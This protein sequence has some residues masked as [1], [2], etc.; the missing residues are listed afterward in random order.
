MKLN[1]T[2]IVAFLAVS[3]QAATVEWGILTGPDWQYDSGERH[4]RGLVTA[5]ENCRMSTGDV[6]C[7]WLSLIGN[8]SADNARIVLSAEETSVLEYGD[9]WV[10]MNE[11]DLVDATIQDADTFFLHGIADPV[12][13][14][15]DVHSDYTIEGMFASSFQFYLGFATSVC[16]EKFDESGM[17]DQHIYYGWAQFEWKNGVLSLVNSAINL[18]GGGIYAGTDRTT[19][20][21]EPSTAMLAL[22]GLALLIK[23]RRA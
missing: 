15:Y 1:L 7:P 8:R 16:I 19:P 5:P 14:A 11:G 6:I 17:F 20:V 10:R 12:S 18:E 3:G 23:R 21:P 9:N 13:G 22:A 4:W 2:T